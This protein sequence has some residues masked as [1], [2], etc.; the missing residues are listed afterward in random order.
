MMLQE[1]TLRSCVITKMENLSHLTALERLELY[2][3]QI[4][5][6][7]ELAPLSKLRIL[8]LSYNLINNMSAVAACPLLE[9]VYI[10]QNRLR[11]IQ[12]LE[13]LTR[14]RKVST[15]I[16]CMYMLPS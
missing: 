7:A 14:L 15:C 4:L 10:A 5:T 12:G 6:L 16:E 9:E 2:D 3:N 1:L 8:D 11:T 13:G